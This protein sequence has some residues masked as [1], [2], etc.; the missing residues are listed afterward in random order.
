MRSAVRVA[1]A[2]FLL[3]FAGLLHNLSNAH[4]LRE[5]QAPAEFDGQAWV[6]P[7]QLL[8]TGPEATQ[9]AADD[10]Q[11]SLP[12]ARLQGGDA[13]LPARSQSTLHEHSGGARHV[14]DEA[15]HEV[16]GRVPLAAASEGHRHVALRVSTGP[17][18]R[19]NRIE[20]LHLSSVL[21]T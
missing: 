9:E 13:T 4:F 11:P 18:R 17:K 10:A 2:R 15:A 19:L 16:R 20:A 14:R 12:T 21:L 5:L 6:G 3:K 1:S 7:I 8:P